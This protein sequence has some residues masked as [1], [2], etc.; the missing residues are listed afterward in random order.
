MGGAIV[1]RWHRA[2]FLL[3]LAGLGACSSEPDFD[4]RYGAASAR[5]TETA[6]DIDA[7]IAGTGVPA[8]DPAAE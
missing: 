6:H 8:Q 2:A 4:E 5:I 7:S 3:L 1:R